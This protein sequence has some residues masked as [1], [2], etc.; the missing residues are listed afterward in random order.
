MRTTRTVL[1]QASAVRRAVTALDARA[2]SER[3]GALPLS[4]VS[5]LGRIATQ[6]PITPGELGAELGMLPQS[7][8]RPLARL[9]R[10]GLVRRTPDPADGRSALLEAT[11]DGLAALRAEFEPR[12]RWLAE[13]MTAACDAEDRATL[14]RAATI[15]Q[16]LVHHGGGVAPREL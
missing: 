4:Q 1:D 12:T 11:A 8:T 7:L 13:A 3:G 9:E 2:R 15:M 10:D 5:V 14:V 16:R 6:G